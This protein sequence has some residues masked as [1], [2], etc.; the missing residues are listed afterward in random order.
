[1]AEMHD[2]VEMLLN[3]MKDYPEDFV[4]E[5]NSYQ[6]NQTKWQKALSM[7]QGVTSPQERAALD[8]RLEEAQ[9]VVYM[10]AA[11]KAMLSDEE[12]E[13]IDPRVY[14]LGN[15]KTMQLS[16]DG[17]LGIGLATQNAAMN[18]IALGK[19]TL[20]EDDLRGMKQYATNHA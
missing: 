20:S 17:S 19:T 10:G 3:R 5:P 15:S 13:E 7:V 11:L 6:M 9:R 4:A 18:T 2:V 14:R 1:M 16:V 12:E 8:I